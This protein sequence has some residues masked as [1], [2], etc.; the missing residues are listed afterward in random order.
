MFGDRPVVWKLWLFPLALLFVASLASLLRRFAP[1]VAMPLLIFLVLSPAFLPGLNLMMDIPALALSL[2][3][4]VL[5]FRTCD[6]AS[7]SLA[8]LAGLTAGLAMQTK[9]TA[10]VDPAI[11][12]IYALL[13]R[14]VRLGIITTLVAAATFASWETAI[15]FRYGESHF[16]YQIFKGYN[17][18]QP[19]ILLLGSLAPLLGS[20]APTLALLA[21]TVLPAP[22]WLILLA[23]LL[24]ILPFLLLCCPDALS[25]DG[26]VYDPANIL[27][28]CNGTGILL[29][30]GW[31]SWRLVATS[32]RFVSPKQDDR[33]AARFL[34]IW[35]AL[36]LTGYVAISPFPRPP[37]HGNYHRRNAV[38]WL[39]A[40]Q[41]RLE[42]PHRNMLYGLVI[43]TL[44]LGLG[45][46]A[47]DYLDARAEQEAPYAAAE[48]IRREHPQALIWYAG[49]WGFQY[50][51]EECGMRQ[52]IPAHASEDGTRLCY[53]RRASAEGIGSS[54]PTIA[55]RSKIWTWTG[56]N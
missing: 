10:A 1:S 44:L 5:F 51:A 53:R 6:Q 13:K 30:M 19:K 22:R 7:P 39:L 17:G 49:Y 46:L 38:A 35:F 42:T 48:L 18:D 28:A 32:S 23:V 54:S 31:A 14:K 8:I 52:I 47:I 9:Y 16:V 56:R 11:V 15:F 43:V 21:L 4:L 33:L 29:S 26:T 37:D 40:N 27:F 2:L 55:Y 36:E 34:V 24:F 20:A 25:G 12:L 45:F 3:A 50:Y 41:S